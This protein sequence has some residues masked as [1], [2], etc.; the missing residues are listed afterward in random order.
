M[1]KPASFFVGPP[2]R[3]WCTTRVPHGLGVRGYNGLGRQSTP[4]ARRTSRRVGY[5][6]PQM[7][8]AGERMNR[9]RLVTTTTPSRAQLRRARDARPRLHVRAIATAPAP[10]APASDRQPRRRGTS[11][12]VKR[13]VAAPPL[14]L[15]VTEELRRR[16]R[17]RL[18][19]PQGQL[20]RRPALAG[21]HAYRVAV[22]PDWNEPTQPRAGR[23][24]RPDRR[25]A[26]EGQRWS[27][28]PQIHRPEARRPCW[29]R[30]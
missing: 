29:S 16:R 21:A 27:P 13:I 26:A 22:I 20:P 12:H 30:S 2:A 15:G 4:L 23:R 11:Q 8:T 1:G 14:N 3:A 10:A 18:A 25:S 5:D 28:A 6:P 7:Q 19:A 17:H 9:N 24:R